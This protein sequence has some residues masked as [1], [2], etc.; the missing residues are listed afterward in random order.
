MGFRSLRVI[1][2]RRVEAGQASA[3]IRIVTRNL[4]LRHRWE[5]EHNEAWATAASLRGRLAIHHAGNGLF[6]SEFNPSPKKSVHFLQIWLKPTMSAASRATR[7]SR[8]PGGQPN[9]D[10]IVC[11]RARGDAWAFVRTQRF[12]FGK[13]EAKKQIVHRFRPA[14]PNGA[15]D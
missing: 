3:S 13:L 15:R 2:R 5:L 11:G 7:R 12:F 4:Q 14:G 10:V 1:K 6:H 9:T 8:S